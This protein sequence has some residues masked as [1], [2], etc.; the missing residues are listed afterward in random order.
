VGSVEANEPF[1]F[2]K[3]LAGHDDGV[4]PGDP[5]VQGLEFRCCSPQHDTSRHIIYKQ[6]EEK[7][8]DVVSRPKRL[9]DGWCTLMCNL[10]L[11]IGSKGELGALNIN[12]RPFVQQPC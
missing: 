12:Q 1:C 11:H 5:N 8:E 2:Q 9:S 4:T 7:L 6:W 3:E 10:T